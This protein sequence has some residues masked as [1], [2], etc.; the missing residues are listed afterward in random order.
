LWSHWWRYSSC[1]R[2]PFKGFN[3]YQ[4]IGRQGYNVAINVFETLTTYGPDFIPKPMLATSWEQP[5][6]N[7]W[8]FHLRND[9]SFHDGTPFDAEAVK[10]SVE[11]IKQSPQSK[12][13]GAVSEVKVVDAHTVDFVLSGP[14]PTLPAVL[15]QTYESIVSP[16]AYKKAGPDEFAKH[17]VGTGP[18]KFESQ[19]SSGS[20]T[21][22]RNCSRATWIST[23]KFLLPL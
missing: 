22:T 15:T 12:S 4:S 18:F 5:D 11:Q 8:R 7:T 20:V 14:F 9:V 19:D 23:T 13:L 3:P 16:A 1:H 2:F 17:P 6:A 10:F 21:L